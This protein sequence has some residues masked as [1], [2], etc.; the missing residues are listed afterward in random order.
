MKQL[1]DA[2]LLMCWSHSGMRGILGLGIL[3]AFPAVVLF[4]LL[5]D[6]PAPERGVLAAARES[7]PARILSYRYDPK[8]G[9]IVGVQASRGSVDVM[10]SGIDTP[11]CDHRTPLEAI[12][13]L[14]R[15]APRGKTVRVFI[16][17]PATPLFP[18]RGHL[19]LGNEWLNGAL[20]ERGLAQ[21]LRPSPVT[22]FNAGRAALEQLQSE[23]QSR[24]RGL[25]RRRL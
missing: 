25:W 11:L 21:L 6:S 14:E 5:T 3:T 13:W 12:K 1:L 19:V 16:L 8:R 22:K 23:A 7:W 15:F 4:S 2:L 24:Q 18:T 17:E 10:F 20:L 9:L